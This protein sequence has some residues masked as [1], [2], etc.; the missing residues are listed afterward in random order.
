MPLPGGLTSVCRARAV[1]EDFQ[2]VPGKQS[3]QLDSGSLGSP[4]SGLGPGEEVLRKVKTHSGSLRA[5]GSGRAKGPKDGKETGK[6][7]YTH[8]TE[9]VMC[10]LELRGSLPCLL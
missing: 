3:E 10:L 2:Q 6:R 1:G 9:G 4:R 7:L 5:W 8:S